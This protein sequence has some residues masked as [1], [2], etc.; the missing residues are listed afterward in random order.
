VPT[1][2]HVKPWA[3]PWSHEE[4]SSDVG[5]VVVHGFMANPSGMRRLGAA[6]ADAGFNVEIPR[7]P[8]HGTSLRDFAATRY[9]DYRVAVDQVVDDLCRRVEHV[10][11][12]GH[13]L[14]GTL[15]L[16]TIAGRGRAGIAGPIA[17]A[18]TINAQVIP[19]EDPVAKLGALL[20]YVFILAPRE[21]VALPTDDIA[22]SG[23]TERA[24]RF[25]PGRTGY[26]VSREFKRVAGVLGDVEVPLLVAYSPGDNCVPHKNSLEL[27]RRV[28]SEDVTELRLERS[29]HVALLDH[30][31]ELLTDGIIDFVRRVTA[32]REAEA[33]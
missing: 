18:V 22:R 28:G 2:T 29:Q 32:E 14:G 31:A 17:G 20:Q 1:E 11:L 13:S 24:Y 12:V 10:V 4:P 30:D 25:V 16:D 7:L 8:G 15:I 5:V 27:I 3:E 21:L 23:T 6:L 9:A 19:R 33:V 26:S